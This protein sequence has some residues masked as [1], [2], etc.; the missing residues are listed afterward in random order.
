MSVFYLLYNKDNYRTLSLHILP[1][2]P[3]YMYVDTIYYTVLMLVLDY[4]HCV[5]MSIIQISWGS[6]SAEL[7]SFDM[8]S[9][10]IV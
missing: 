5:S 4:K 10:V 8:I 2:S 3:L 6:M 7:D 1:E 9:Y